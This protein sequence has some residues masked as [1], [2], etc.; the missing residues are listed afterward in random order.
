MTANSNTLVMAR[1]TPLAAVRNYLSITK[2]AIIL[3]LLITTVPAM[4]VA[5]GGWPSTWLVLAT[6]IG[7]AAS[8][9]GANAVNCWYDRDIDAIMKRTRGRPLVTGEIDPA[10]GL[11]FG[12][13]LGAGAFVFL[14]ATTT[15]LA[16]WLTLGAYLFYTVVYTMWLKRRT[17]QNIVIGGAA[18]A[19]PPMIGWAAVTGDMSWAAVVMFLIVFLWT[20]PHWRFASR[21]T[22]PMPAC[23][24]SRWSKAPSAPG[25]RSSSTL[26]PWPLRPCRCS[27][28]AASAGPTRR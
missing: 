12:L 9:G 24:C 15:P 17:P 19:F 27:W 4:V 7:G 20:P 2:P 21:A 8:A 5:Q 1:S 16:A 3:L 10:K 28:S 25:A 6:L 13:A 22:T 18:G 14:Y 11:A 26:L 23:Q